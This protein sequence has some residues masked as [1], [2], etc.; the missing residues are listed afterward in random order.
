MVDPSSGKLSEGFAKSADCS[1]ML[2]KTHQKLESC[3]H[4]PIKACFN[5]LYLSLHAV[6]RLCQCN[7]H[8]AFLWSM[9]WKNNQTSWTK[10]C[11][12]RTISFA[13]GKGERSTWD[14]RKAKAAK[15][16]LPVEKILIIGHP[17]FPQQRVHF[18]LK[19]DVNALSLIFKSFVNSDIVSLTLNSEG[20]Y[21]L[22]NQALVSIEWI[23]KINYYF[24]WFWYQTH[25]RRFFLSSFILFHVCF[26]IKIPT[27]ENVTDAP[28]HYNTCNSNIIKI[29]KIDKPWRKSKNQHEQKYKST[30]EQVEEKRIKHKAL[31]LGGFFFILQISI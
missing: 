15:P 24:Q 23:T 18:S 11:T 14:H 31:G 7:G 5:F 21:M 12:A 10:H 13:C 6:P 8:R 16:P 30:H 27:K 26:L 28:K 1:L 25:N 17:Q 9:S 19:Q 22:S 3:S 20:Q 4:T 29:S 2:T